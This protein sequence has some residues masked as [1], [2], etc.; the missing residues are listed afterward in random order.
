MVFIK[1]VALNPILSGDLQDAIT[2]APTNTKE[3]HSQGWMAASDKEPKSIST[4][5]HSTLTLCKH[6]EL[7]DGL[8]THQQFTKLAS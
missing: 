7:D 6:M 4:T 2:Q 3:C 1:L 8:E 5:S